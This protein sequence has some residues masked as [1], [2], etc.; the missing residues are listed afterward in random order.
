ME[1]LCKQQNDDNIVDVYYLY[2]W[3]IDSEDLF[4]ILILK[5]KTTSF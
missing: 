2:I 3:F 4:F 1:L 5:E